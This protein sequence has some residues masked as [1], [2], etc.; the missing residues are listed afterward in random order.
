MWC[1]RQSLI[2]KMLGIVVAPVLVFGACAVGIVVTGLLHSGEQVFFTAQTTLL[3]AGATMLTTVCALI[4]GLHKAVIQPFGCMQAAIQ[5]IALGETVSLPDML[6]QDEI[7]QLE[8][9]IVSLGEKLQQQRAEIICKTREYQILFDLVPC[10]LSV[11][12][13]AFKLLRWNNQFAVRFAP[14]QGKTCYEVYKGRSTP[15]PDC[16]VA[17]TWTEGLTQCNQESRLNPDGTRDYWFV[18]TIPLRDE[19][20]T[21][22]SVMEMSIDMTLIHT[23][24]NQLQHSEQAHK[25]IFDS[26]PNAV[27]SL[28]A[29]T[30]IILDCNPASVKMYN[31]ARRELIGNSILELF[32]P[33]E[34]EQYA[35]QLKAF[36]VFSGVTTVRADGTPILVDIRS[37]TA[38]VE[39]RQVRILCAAD[40]TE[41]LEMEQK[42]IQA[43][44]MT[45]LGEMATGVAHELN[46][47]LTVIKGAVSYFLRKMQR[48]GAVPLEHLLEMSQEMN[49]QVDR[50]SDIINHMRAFGRKSDVTL[51]DVNIND[52]VRHACDLFGRQLAVHGITL[53]LELD[54]TVSLVRAIPNRL[55]QI[56]VN[57]VLNARDAVEDCHRDNPENPQKIG[58]Q[59]HEVVNT[60]VLVV[61]DTG[62]GVPDHLR[63]KIF[64][65][66]FTT[67]AVGKGTGLG[68]SIIYGLIKDF[69]GS[70][71]V[72]NRAEGGA[73]FEIAF[74]AA[75]KTP[76]S[77]QETPSEVLAEDQ[78]VPA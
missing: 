40:C 65:P 47:P 11:Q 7:G 55:E 66:F 13:K 50:A 62:T 68:L 36:T 10:S 20:G 29:D 15:C 44:K 4:V 51:Q 43:G 59:T 67:K 69:G 56:I 31:K 76:V 77:Q 58:L 57:L 21:I 25:A 42:L 54:P 49:E 32:V 17:R 26:M 34:R 9:S 22:T 5:R 53:E 23:L 35:S 14:E 2:G 24:Q 6:R 45:T 78:G 61:W 39:N 74:P 27:F 12:D 48:D 16:S 30:L 3:L 18:Q 37:A 46:Q 60:V 73:Q 64:E 33:A 72:C 19:T 1:T 75:G 38:V 28:D 63:H 41:R 52:R 71:T 70:I 8:R